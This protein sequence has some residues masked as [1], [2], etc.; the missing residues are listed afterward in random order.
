MNDNISL[1]P[2]FEK[3]GKN[4]NDI[5]LNDVD[6]FRTA[7]LEVS[8]DTLRTINI[9]T[10]DLEPAIYDYQPFLDNIL[11]LC[12]GNRHA[13]V[14]ILVQNSEPVIKRGH[15]LIR[16]AQRLTSAIE[17]RNPHE[18][19]VS[20]RSAFMVADSQRFVYREN[21]ETY[22]GIYNMDCRYRSK[23]LEELFTQMWEHSE[24]DVQLRRLVI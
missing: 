21:T 4:E 8:K 3:Q 16:L 18:E 10:P 20:V 7:L 12:R 1:L 15:G 24:A 23:S 13:R 11:E 22:R 9:L 6:G 14:Q 2:D 17:I 19:Y 5:I